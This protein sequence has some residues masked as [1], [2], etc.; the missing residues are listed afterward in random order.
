MSSDGSG[1]TDA[2]DASGVGQRRTEG[3]IRALVDRETAI[4]SDC[5]REID[6]S[7]ARNEMEVVA[8]LEAHRNEH[9][10]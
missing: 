8:D 6:V 7:R 2:A 10:V 5:G 3:I 1:A 4:C 9:H